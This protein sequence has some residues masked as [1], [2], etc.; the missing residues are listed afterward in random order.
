MIKS[1]TLT[2]KN[3]FVISLPKNRQRSHACICMHLLSKN[4]ACMQACG[5][6]CMH[7]CMH[8]HACDNPR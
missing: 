3:A 5:C 2:L 1:K 4:R 7:A 8:L 6:M